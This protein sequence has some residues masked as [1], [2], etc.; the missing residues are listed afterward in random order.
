M[1]EGKDQL[2][3]WVRRW[4]LQQG[5]EPEQIALAGDSAGGGLLRMSTHLEDFNPLVVWAALLLTLAYVY[6]DFSAY[7]DIAIGSARL[8]GL[9]IMENF[10]LPFLA[11]SLQN[12]WQR[13]HMT[14]ANWCRT[15]IYMPMIG[16]TRNPY[17][18]VIATF[19]V[20]GLW[21]SAGPHW[22]AWGLWHGLGLAFLLQWSRFTAK[23][24][25]KIMK[26]PGG[27]V[28]GWAMTM[29]YVALGGAFTAM[30]QQASISVS[31]AIIA[32]AFGLTFSTS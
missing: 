6:L 23:R 24:K 3:W 10:N 22:V 32:S 2:G 14:L 21:H 8:F 27:K 30:H 20:M 25:I 11:T 18:A 16:L 15:Y 12:F 4:L 31:L 28:A 13:W 1:K 19:V 29:C 17:W 26:S 5:Y 9:K 7:T